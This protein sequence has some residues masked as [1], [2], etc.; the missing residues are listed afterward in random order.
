MTGAIRRDANGAVV[1]LG[2]FGHLWNARI[3]G[4]EGMSQADVRR[5]GQLLVALPHCAFGLVCSVSTTGSE[6]VGC[7]YAIGR[8]NCGKRREVDKRCRIDLVLGRPGQLLLA[9]KTA[10]M[11]LATACVM[12]AARAVH[13]RKWHAAVFTAA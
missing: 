7:G 11:F 10:A 1:T 12:A 4:R 6:M 8:T 13:A 2:R 9:G 5:G 3:R